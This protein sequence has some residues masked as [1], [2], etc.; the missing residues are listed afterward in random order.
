ML[1]GYFHRD[2]KFTMPTLSHNPLQALFLYPMWDTTDLSREKNCTM[3]VKNNVLIAF[4]CQ[5]F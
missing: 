1:Y 3:P 2:E 5:N 4:I